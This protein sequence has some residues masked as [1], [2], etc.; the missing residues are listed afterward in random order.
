MKCYIGRHGSKSDRQCKL[1]ADEFESV[2]H[3]LWE[4]PVHTAIRNTFIGELDSCGAVLKV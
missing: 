4:C 3:V 2:I 1:C